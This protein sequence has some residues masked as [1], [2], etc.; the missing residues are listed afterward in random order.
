VKHRSDA[1]LYA[2][3]GAE[4]RLRNDAFAEIYERHAHR[5][6]L[7]C[8][9]FIGE[10]AQA[11]DIFQETF[12]LFVRSFEPDRAI[13]NL[14]AYLL[15]IARNL[16]LRYRRDANQRLVSIEGLEIGHVERPMEEEELARLVTSTLDLLPEEQREA[17]V[18]QAY[19]GLSYIEIAEVTGVPVSTVRNR[20]VR[21][22]H[23]VREIVSRYYTDVI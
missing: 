23:K 14:P 16:C 1:E 8:R 17:F 10:Q 18:L 3:L 12:L 7:Y 2:L 19:S 4:A 6:F 13:T 22:K 5:V 15:R 20:V 21:A 9:K 11:D